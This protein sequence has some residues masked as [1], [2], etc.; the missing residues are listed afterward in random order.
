MIIFKTEYHKTFSVFGIDQQFLHNSRMVS[1]GNEFDRK[2]DFKTIV[3]P[4][5]DMKKF[6]MSKSSI[7]PLFVILI[8]AVANTANGC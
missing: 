7:L 4:W 5:I 1:F 3:F 2:I 6:D 8:Y